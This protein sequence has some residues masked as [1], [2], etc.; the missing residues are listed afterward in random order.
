M[1]AI[2]LAAGCGRRL[3]CD[4]PKALL[5]IGGVTLLER[6]VGQLRRGGIEDIFVICGYQRDLIETAAAQLRIITIYNPD[7]DRSDNLVSFRVGQGQLAGRCLMC[8][9]D[10]IAEENLVERL[11]ISPGDVVLPMDRESVE[12]ESMKIRLEDGQVVELSK[13][14][15]TQQASGESIPMM[16]FS[17][18]F[19]AALKK[20]TDASVAQSRWDRL[21]DDA[22]FEVIQSREFCTT[23]LDA[24]GLKWM[25]IDTPADLQKAQ[26]LFSRC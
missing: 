6:F 15:P 3:G 12:T 19:L 20:I 18:K 17:G 21:L 25:E 23:V 16:V 22:I 7:Y 26:F 10:F 5:E 8:H 13:T 14:I 11:L 2:I 9:G 24:T 4:Q 1:Q